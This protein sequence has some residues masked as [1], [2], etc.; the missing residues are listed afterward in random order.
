MGIAKNEN[1]AEDISQ[2]DNVWEMLGR[3]LFYWLKSWGSA[4]QSLTLNLYIK[5]KKTEAISRDI[6]SKA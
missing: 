2:Y 1:L 6:R 3:L 4:A 5:L